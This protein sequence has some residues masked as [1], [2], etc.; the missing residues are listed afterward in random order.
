M[1]DIAAEVDKLH[2]LKGANYSR[3]VELIALMGDFHPVEGETGI[4]STGGK[5][6][7]DYD[8]LLNAAR[9][10]VAHGYNKPVESCVVEYD[11]PI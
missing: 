4:F 6:E 7:D 3:Q 8:N 1:N 9:R 10:A 11:Y 5:S 2:F